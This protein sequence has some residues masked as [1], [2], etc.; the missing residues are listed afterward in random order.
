MVALGCW[1]SA[2]PAHAGWD[3]TIGVGPCQP[4]YVPPSFQVVTVPQLVTWIDGNGFIHQDIRYVRVL[5][6]RPPQ[7]Y[8]W[9]EPRQ[10]YRGGDRRDIHP[11]F[12]R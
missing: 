5:V 7:L 11:Y 6:E 1:L 8:N 12:R 10:T 9:F 3:I 4:V 2:A